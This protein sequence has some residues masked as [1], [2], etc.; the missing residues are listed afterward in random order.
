MKSGLKKALILGA[1]AATTIGIAL[2][3][4]SGGFTLEQLLE[5]RDQLLTF[6]EA[7]AI[8]AALLFILAYIA[9]VAFS[10]PGATVLTLLGG[11]LFE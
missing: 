8:A 11:F 5:S 1:L 2:A 9:V 6:V 4:R 3:M 10:I 7:R